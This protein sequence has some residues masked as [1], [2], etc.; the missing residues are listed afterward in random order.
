MYFV[1]NE[2][3]TNEPVPT[4]SC[5]G[6]YDRPSNAFYLYNELL[7]VLSGPLTPGSSTTLQNSRCR[8]IGLYSSAIGAGNQLSVTIAIE[9]L[10]GFLV[11]K[12]IY[13]LVQDLNGND[14]RASSGW[15]S[16][17]WNQA[18][19]NAPPATSGLPPSSGSGTGPVTLSGTYS[20]ANGYN[21]IGMAHL[22]V[23][24]SNGT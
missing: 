15:K 6:F 12:Y 23:V 5:H 21:D 8:V 3:T 9:R 2:A 24:A 18:S 14:S 17:S 1:V 20:D 10:G 19:F 16:A 7:T 13:L 4:T 11:N 22:R